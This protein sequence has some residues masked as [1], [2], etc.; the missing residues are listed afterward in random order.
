M[1]NPYTKRLSTLGIEMRFI[2][3]PKNYMAIKQEG[4]GA[5][6]NALK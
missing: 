2:W 6:H 1:Q 3:A 5:M 4:F